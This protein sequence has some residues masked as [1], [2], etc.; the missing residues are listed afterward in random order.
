MRGLCLILDQDLLRVSPEQAMRQALDAGVKFFQYRSKNG[1]RKSIH[2]T[3]LMLS[4]I[5]RNAQALFLVNDHADIA[6]AVDADGVHLGQDD[7]PIEFAR[8]LLGRDKLIGISTHNLEQARAAEAAGADYIG[9]GPIF[10]S[11]TKDAGQTQ[12]IQNL[13]IIKNSV[14]IPVIAIGGINQAN[15]QFVAQA[16]ADGAAVISGVLTAPDITLAAEQLVSIWTNF[17]RNT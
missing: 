8:K 1:A 6:A 9:F 15:V 12:G 16:G 2:E 10:K 7:L 4:R 13:T 3:T 5:A 11:S 17:R 14:A